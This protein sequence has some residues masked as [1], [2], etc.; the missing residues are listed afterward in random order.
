MKL[1]ISFCNTETASIL[2]ERKISPLAYLDTQS[3]ALSWI[4]LPIIE[5]ASGVSGLTCDQRFIYI[6]Y[7]MPR[8]E[9]T[10]IVILHKKT[11]QLHKQYHIESIL[12]AHS[13]AIRDSVL[14]IV[15]T[16]TDTIYHINLK[17]GFLDLSSLNVFWKPEGCKGNADT[18]H[19]NAIYNTPDRLIVSAFGKKTTSEKSSAKKGYIYD[20]TNGRYIEKDIYHPHSVVELGGEL[21]Y[22]ESASKSVYSSTR[23]QL[24]FNIGYMRGLCITKNQYLIAARSSGR[25]VSRSTGE[26]NN[27]MD[28]GALLQSCS[29]TMLRLKNGMRFNNFSYIFSAIKNN[30]YFNYRFNDYFREIYDVISLEGS[31]RPKN[32]WSKLHI[33]KDTDISLVD[34]Q[35][36]IGQATKK[37]L[38]DMYLFVL[39]VYKIKAKAIHDLFESRRINTQMK[40]DL[41]FERNNVKLLQN[42]INRIENSTIFKIYQKVKGILI[43]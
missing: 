25:E 17:K 35:S 37:D 33:P 13:L 14:F 5:H 23:G 32:I 7:Q 8:S 43:R 31:I 18:H 19:I 39:D 26:I 21:F 22:C 16:G 4:K 36:F 30:E 6:A 12:D 11:F 27:I 20:L 9:G 1:L 15:S 38:L 2:A 24:K 3:N 29:I 28:K 34:M 42:R 10:V 41:A 40:K